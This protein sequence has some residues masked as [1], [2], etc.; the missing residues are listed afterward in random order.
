M[1]IFSVPILHATTVL[2]SSSSSTSSFSSSLSSSPPPPPRRRLLH[3][4]GRDLLFFLQKKKNHIVSTEETKLPH[5]HSFSSSSSSL[6]YRVKPLLPYSCF[7]SGSSFHTEDMGLED[8]MTDE[9][10]ATEEKDNFLP[11]LCI[12]IFLLQW[13]FILETRRSF[14]TG[15]LQHVSR[16][17]VQH[18]STQL[19]LHQVSIKW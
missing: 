14:I 7:R 19:P 1:A 17:L 12:S 9:S 13:S 2:S 3:H 18:F 11:S 16:Y 5:F 6:D 4:H 10:K 15:F 8:S